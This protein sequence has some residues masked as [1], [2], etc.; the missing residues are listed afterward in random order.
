[1]FIFYSQF[2]RTIRPSTFSFFSKHIER[3]RRRGEPTDPLF[4]YSFILVLL[5]IQVEE[6]DRDVRQG[7]IFMCDTVAGSVS[8]VFNV[9]IRVGTDN[10]ILINIL[11]SFFIDFSFKK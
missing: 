6:F 10:N 8:V 5:G 7:H 11:V 1:M 9:I 2:F 3:I 4:V